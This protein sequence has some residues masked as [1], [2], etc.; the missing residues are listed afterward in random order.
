MEHW[1]DFITEKLEDA[2]QQASYVKE[3]KEEVGIPSQ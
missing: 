1:K 2:L 3:G